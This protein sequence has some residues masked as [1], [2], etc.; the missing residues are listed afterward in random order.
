MQ[1]E[2]LEIVNSVIDGWKA[3]FKNFLKFFVTFFVPSVGYV[4][5][6]LLFSVGLVLLLKL[7]TYPSAVLLAVLGL[8]LAVVGLAMFLYFFW[9]FLVISASTYIVAQ[10]LFKTGEKP[11]YKEAN[12]AIETRAKDY[13]ILLLLLTLI[14]IAPFIIFYLP[15]FL[16]AVASPSLVPID[17][18]A[19]VNMGAFSLSFVLFAIVNLFLLLAVPLFALNE[20]LSPKNCVKLS[21]SLVGKNF[22]PTVLFI[23]FFLL[24][25]VPVTL[26]TLI[27]ILGTVVINFIWAIVA[28][29]LTALV[30][31]KWY[32]EVTKKTVVEE[33]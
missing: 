28:T 32:L 19:A 20:N 33:C 15:L 7:I 24:T 5:G 14:M 16:L 21:F 4:A 25:I 23:L 13:I 1:E 29:P 10:E 11:E 2:K 31:T 8:I 30:L 12:K 3:L 18:I 17:S 9:R 27:P 22:L 26:L 6:L